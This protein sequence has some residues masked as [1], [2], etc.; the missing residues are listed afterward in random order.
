MKFLLTLCASFVVAVS[1]AIGQA[2]KAT[3]SVEQ[4]LTDKVH[5]M[6]EG[7]RQGNVH[8]YLGVAVPD[9]V[10]IDEEDV[11]P[12]RRAFEQHLSKD[13]GA[14]RKISS[15]DSHISNLQVFGDFARIDVTSKFVG[16]LP[17]KKDPAVLHHYVVELK[18]KHE[19]RRLDGDWKLTRFVQLGETGTVDGK[20]I[21]AHS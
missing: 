4:Q 7:L 14:F 13:I 3:D 19:W 12:T 18:F 2:A 21:S 11:F 15:F 20:A 6:D 1:V 5:Q 10:T 8:A 17:D 16:D 9:L